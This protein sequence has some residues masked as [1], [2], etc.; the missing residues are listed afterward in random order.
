MEPDMGPPMRVGMMRGGVMRMDASDP[1]REKRGNT[2]GHGAYA[3][4]KAK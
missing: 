1:L 2:Q 3:P 4:H